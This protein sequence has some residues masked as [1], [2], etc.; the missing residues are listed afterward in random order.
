MYNTV[1]VNVLYSINSTY[2]T[3]TFKNVHKLY[4][5]EFGVGQNA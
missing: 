2:N 4:E 5:Y 3:S 1:D